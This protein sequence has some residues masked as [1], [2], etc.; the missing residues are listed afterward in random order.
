MII[1]YLLTTVLLV[2]FAAGDTNETTTVSPTL[3]TSPP[4]SG[5]LNNGTCGQNGTCICPECIEI[6]FKL[7]KFTVEFKGTKAIIAK[8]TIIRA[9]PQ[10]VGL[11]SAPIFLEMLTAYVLKDMKVPSKTAYIIGKSLLGRN[12][13]KT[14]N[15]CSCQNGGQCV[16]FRAFPVCVCP[17]DQDGRPLFN[18]M[19]CEN[20]LPKPDNSW[21]VIPIASVTIV[22]GFA[23][24]LL[25]TVATIGKLRKCWSRD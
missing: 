8:P 18:G 7:I 11:E 13:E 17:Q 25:I 2:S 4:C 19:R 3:A 22:C 21:P 1:Q 14:L 15:E 16:K 10:I 23:A 9:P 24:I 6:T 5:C 12:C 20:E